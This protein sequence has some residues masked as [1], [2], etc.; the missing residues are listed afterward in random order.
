[1]GD[2]FA[3]WIAYNGFS[4]HAMIRSTAIKGFYAKRGYKIPKSNYTIKKL[5]KNFAKEKT[6][7]L[8]NM[9]TKMN[10]LELVFQ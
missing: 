4:I 10:D 9:F 3:M 2:L 1:M 5:I 6:L 8:K 7:E